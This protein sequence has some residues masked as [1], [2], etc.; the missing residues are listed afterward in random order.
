MAVFRDVVPCNLAEI[1]RPIRDA[2][3]RPDD[4]VSKNIWNDTTRRNP[5]EDGQPLTYSQLWEPEISP[6]WILF[7]PY[8]LKIRLI[9]FDL[10][11]I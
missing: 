7:T 9:S 2:Y 3:Y 6:I 10:T 1:G 11:Y 8:F 5:P 4:G